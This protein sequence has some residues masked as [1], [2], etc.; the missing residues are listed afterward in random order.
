MAIHETLTKI[1][2]VKLY[3]TRQIYN[4]FSNFNGVMRINNS[5]H[6]KNYANKIRIISSELHLF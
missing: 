3:I 4:F 1:K 2:T 6:T 5:K